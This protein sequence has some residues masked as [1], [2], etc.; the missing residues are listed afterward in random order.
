MSCTC[1]VDDKA[2]GRIRHDNGRITSEGPLGEPLEGGLIVFRAEFVLRQTAK[3]RCRM[4]EAHAW[5][6]TR[7]KRLSA[8]RLDHTPSCIV[9]DEN[10]ESLRLRPVS[11]QAPQQSVCRPCW[12]EDRDDPLH[13]TPQQ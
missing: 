7:Q 6:Q 5:T 10:H 8:D 12:K 4:G 2:I 9:S 3:D 1:D 13:H 11:A